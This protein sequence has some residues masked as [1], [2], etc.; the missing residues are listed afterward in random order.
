MY[1]LARMSAAG[2]D[3]HFIFRRMLISACEDT[4][5]ADPAAISVVESAARA[6]DRVGLPEGRY[7]LAHAAL[8]LSTA[9]KS[10]SSM[11]FFDALAS[12]EK[13][14]AD[15]PNHLRDASRDADGFGHGAGYMYPHA[16]RDHW[17]AQQYLPESLAGRVFYTPSSQGYE[18]GIRDEVLSRREA[19][20]AALLERG[21]GGGGA[22][23][24]EIPGGMTP[25]ARTGKAEWEARTD[26][27]YAESLLRL[28]RE[29]T[30]L[31]G[32]ERGSRV[33]VYPAD[34]GLLIWDALRACTEGAVCGVCRS[35]RGRAVLEQ[36]GRTLSEIERP[37]LA[38]ENRVQS[39]G[40]D[41]CGDNTLSVQGAAERMPGTRGGALDEG[42]RAERAGES[43]AASPLF[44]I[45]DE[46]ADIPFDRLFFRDI[47]S[48]PEHIAAFYA[49]LEQA[50]RDGRLAD[51]WRCVF[52]QRLPAAGQRLA[53]LLRE[54]VLPLR[55]REGGAARTSSSEARQRDGAHKAADNAPNG[56]FLP[57]GALAAFEAAENRFYA[58]DGNPLCAWNADTLQSMCPA[59]FS[60]TVETH[61]W[62]ER[63]RLSRAEVERWFAPDS[64]YGGTLRALM[65]EGVHDGADALRA[66]AEAL[67][68]AADA[69]Q[70][71]E[72][73]TAAAMGQIR[74]KLDC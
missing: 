24:A 66:V 69:G 44:R 19:Q 30:R 67:L 28:R 45:P 6:F 73:K 68:S 11:A 5:L 31:A 32:L 52:A 74:Y 62:T 7:F 49:A 58:G 12:V 43:G 18:K 34:D 14:D 21:A 25:N 15:V 20:I 51:G 29:M 2:E 16:Y 9:P 17:V 26:S 37:L 63:R 65:D 35:E 27:G 53:A 61:K 50:E 36:Y 38:L 40:R 57:A 23:D 55:D 41:K 22:D 42:G 13:E 70:T 39:A 56:D 46:F 60:C 10:N 8:Y 1:W 47:I 54:Q 59:A 4:G 33:I 71:V 64:R 72:W 48:L 3:P